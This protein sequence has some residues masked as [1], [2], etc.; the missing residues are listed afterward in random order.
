MAPKGRPPDQII[1]YLLTAAK[2][3]S[4]TSS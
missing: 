2:E 3:A 1:V 4:H